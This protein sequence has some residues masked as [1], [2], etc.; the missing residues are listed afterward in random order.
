MA[1]LTWNLPF[2]HLVHKII[3]DISKDLRVTP[4]AL[5]LLQEAA[6]A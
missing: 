1:L 5:E 6:E 3:Q 4:D 2:R